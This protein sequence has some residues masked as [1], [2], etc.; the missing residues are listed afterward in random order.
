MDLTYEA[1]TQVEHDTVY[2]IIQE[3]SREPG[4]SVRIAFDRDAND[5]YVA[6]VVGDIPIAF[7]DYIDEIAGS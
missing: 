1:M 2:I 5:E 3:C 4:V 7:R 6:T